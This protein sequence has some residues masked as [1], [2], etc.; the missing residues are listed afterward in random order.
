MQGFERQCAGCGTTFVVCRRCRLRRYCSPIC[1]DVERTRRVRGYQRDYQRDFD[2]R[3]ARAVRCKL[4]RE[5]K[6]AAHFEADQFVTARAPE[7]TLV[8][9]PTSPIGVRQQEHDDGLD[10]ARPVPGA[11]EHPDSSTARQ[12][13]LPGGPNRREHPGV[14]R[15]E[16]VDEGVQLALVWEHVPS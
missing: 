6:K 8:P 5:A 16:F 1:R 7:P 14:E 4:Q 15:D 9:T 10:L 2:V 3:R 11:A 12:K 13:F